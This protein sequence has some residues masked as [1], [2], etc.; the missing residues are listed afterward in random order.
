MAIRSKLSILTASEQDELYSPPVFSED[1]Q[2]F[3]F[4]SSEADW[5]SIRRG[6]YRRTQ[7]M[8]ILQGYFLSKPVILQ[9][10]Q[11]PTKVRKVP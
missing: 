2:R 3:F 11:I 1:D 6:R 4:S 10:G 9:L 7:C 8:Q 5:M